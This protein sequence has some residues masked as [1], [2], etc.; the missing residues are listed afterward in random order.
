MIN[1]QTVDQG[2]NAAWHATATSA[3][4]HFGHL[5]ATVIGCAAFG[6]PLVLAEQWKQALKA[7]KKMGVRPSIGIHD[8]IIFMCIY[9]YHR[10]FSKFPYFYIV[11]YIVPFS[12]SRTLIFFTWGGP[13]K[14]PSRNSFRW[15]TAAKKLDW[16]SKCLSKLWNPLKLRYKALV[17]IKF[18]AKAC[19]LLQTYRITDVEVTAIEYIAIV[20]PGTLTVLTIQQFTASKIS[21]GVLPLSILWLSWFLG[22]M[23]H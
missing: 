18:I 6:L 21:H 13:V 23:F 11:N 5:S 17:D 20:P 1:H 19:H 12:R 9:I 10:L 7:E 22:M 3:A 15:L 4:R 2:A 14:P 16:R 8:L